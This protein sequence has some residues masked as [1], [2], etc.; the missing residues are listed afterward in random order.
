MAVEAQ[1][2]PQCGSAIHFKQGQAS[3]VCDYCGTTVTRSTRSDV[4]LKKEIEEEKI[5]QEIIEREARLY[6]DGQPATAKI[7]TAQTT[8]IIRD[9]PEGKGVIMSFTVEVYP[10]NEAPFDASTT[11]S[12][13]LVAVDKYQPGTVVDV[14]YDPKDHTQVSVEGRHGLTNSYWQQMRKADEQIREGDERLREADEEYQ[15]GEQEYQQG[16]KEMQ[17][18]NEKMQKLKRKS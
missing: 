18:A 16:E 11:T 13:G 12:I 4:S 1:V 8:N 15:K 17:Q 6:T 2:C 10:K 9:A 5:V 3:I 14:S 7:L